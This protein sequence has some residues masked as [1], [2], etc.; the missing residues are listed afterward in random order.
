MGFTTTLLNSAAEH[1][2]R[3]NV[4]AYK[5]PPATYLAGDVAITFDEFHS[6]VNKAISLTT[7]DVD[8]DLGTDSVI[9]LQL[10]IRGMPKNRTSAKDITDRATD[11]LHGLQRADWGGI[12]IVLIEW[13]SQTSHGL[14]ANGREEVSVNFYITCTRTGTH[15]RD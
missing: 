10:W 4:G 13:R 8:R 14:D 6:T 2:H 11:A 15:L 1:L 9:G 7:Y 12:P 3:E 5:L